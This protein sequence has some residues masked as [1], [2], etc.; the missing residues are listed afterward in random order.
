MLITLTNFLISFFLDLV[1][2]F[3]IMSLF[4]IGLVSCLCAAVTKSFPV[5]IHTVSFI[6][7]LDQYWGTYFWQCKSTFIEL[8]CHPHHGGWGGV[9]MAFNS[10]LFIHMFQF[11]SS[12]GALNTEPD[13]QTWISDTKMSLLPGRNPEQDQVRMGDPLA[14]GWPVR[15]RIGEGGG[16][17][18][19]IQS[20]PIRPTW[21]FSHKLL[22]FFLFITAETLEIWLA[23]WAM[24]DT[25]FIKMSTL[26]KTTRCMLIPAAKGNIL[27]PQNKWVRRSKIPWIY[28]TTM[29]WHH[30]WQQIVNYIFTL[31]AF[32]TK[33]DA[34]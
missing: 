23:H 9:T 33:A 26:V 18:S 17:R 14:D 11:W 31:V 34:K 12:P 3:L 13:L 28:H 27:K 1:S 15:K 22:L 30:C 7:S 21:S 5:R 6:Y 29:S 8:Y 19:W 24:M 2:F 20:G 4:K 16:G 32:Q 10:A 25:L